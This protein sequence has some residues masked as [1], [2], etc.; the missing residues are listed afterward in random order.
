M[1]DT[2]LV[3]LVAS[4]V[5]VAGLLGA[6]I[7]WTLSLYDRAAKAEA[8]VAL[9][10]G[11]LPAVTATLDRSADALRKRARPAPFG[12]MNRQRRPVSPRS[13]RR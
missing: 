5:P 4:V 7:K 2:V 8:K 1:S 13:G 11:E 12:S 10:E 6:W 3:A 9:Y